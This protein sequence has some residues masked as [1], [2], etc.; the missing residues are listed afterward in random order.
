ML[1]ILFYLI[2]YTTNIICGK[3]DRNTFW[4]PIESWKCAIRKQQKTMLFSK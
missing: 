4:Q 2:N 1:T 3:F